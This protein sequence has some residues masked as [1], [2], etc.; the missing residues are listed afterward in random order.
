MAR[1]V[2]LLTG[3]TPD[4][5]IFQRLLP[6]LPTAEIVSWIE[7]IRNESIPEYAARLASTIQSSEPVVVCGV[8]FGGII[9]RELAWR[10]N[11]H[12]CVLIS[13]IRSPDEL[14][15][16]IRAIRRGAGIWNNWIFHLLGKFAFA[17]QNISCVPSITRIAKFTGENG[18]WYRWAT[19]SVLRWYPSQQI[20]D[21]PVVQIHGSDDTTF[22]LKF[23][24]PNFVISGGGH[25]I[26]LTHAD[27]IATIICQLSR[28][29]SS[30][31]R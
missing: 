14:P 26:A 10:I 4:S 5:R 7:P 12:T 23:V 15:P 9:A 18:A 19:N 21:V 22:P 16:W 31:S 8:S 30:P 24:H 20:D 11:A 2:L 27:E 3:M 1:R 29:T 25:T 28:F 17:I 6:S 13:S